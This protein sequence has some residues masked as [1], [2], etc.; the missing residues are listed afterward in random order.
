MLFR[1]SAMA[2][3]D[4]VPSLL[5]LIIQNGGRL[6]GSQS[7]QAIQKKDP[8]L[9]KHIED[10]G[11]LKRFCAQHDVLEFITVAGSDGFIQRRESP[12]VVAELILSLV[13]E[14]GGSLSGS[15]AVPAL[16]QR[17]VTFK[18]IVD[19][20]GGLKKF[21]MSQAELEFVTKAGSDGFIRRAKPLSAANKTASSLQELLVQTPSTSASSRASS[22]SVA[23]A[24]ECS[25]D[26]EAALSYLRQKTL[27]VAKKRR[28]GD[29]LRPGQYNDGVSRHHSIECAVD[30]AIRAFSAWQ[31][32]LPRSWDLLLQ[33]PSGGSS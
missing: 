15:L 14:N 22:L 2:A 6:A 13:D 16:R 30:H 29:A 19:D 5:E 32:R 17:G 20:A 23:S 9:R 27:P 10:A 26:D 3:S 7:V 18:R 25:S 4:V 1:S 12:S 11:G 31:R 21:C 33:R 24:S 28:E 8:A